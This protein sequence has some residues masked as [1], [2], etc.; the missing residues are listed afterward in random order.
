MFKRDNICKLFSTM[1][2]YENITMLDIMRTNHV[3]KQI[4]GF[5]SL[6]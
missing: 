5:V 4:F 2:Q 3:L 1:L 6:V